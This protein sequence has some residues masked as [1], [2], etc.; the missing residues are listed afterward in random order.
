MPDVSVPARSVLE[1]QTDQA[2]AA[3][4]RHQARLTERGGLFYGVLAAGLA[5]DLAA[6]FPPGEFPGLPRMIAAFTASLQTMARDMA[7]EPDPAAGGRPFA[8]TVP[9][10]LTIAAMTAAELDKTE[11]G[12]D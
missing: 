7:A 6:E 5:A 9:V 1:A 2:L 8:V 11:A 12:D 10:L 3:Y 4:A